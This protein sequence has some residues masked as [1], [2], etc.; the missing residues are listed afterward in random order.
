MTPPTQFIQDII[1]Y[2]I[3]LQELPLVKVETLPTWGQPKPLDPNLLTLL[4]ERKPGLPFLMEDP[5]QD[6]KL[7]SSCTGDLPPTTSAGCSKEET[8]E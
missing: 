1:K 2:R 8:A 5:S 6:K 3:S 4:A 7:C